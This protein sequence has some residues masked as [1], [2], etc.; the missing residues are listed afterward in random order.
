MPNCTL[1]VSPCTIETWLM[2]TPRR[3]AISWREGR[4]V[5]LAVAVRSRQ[6]L[7]GA[8]RIDADF[9]RLPQADAGAEAADRLRRRDAAGLDVAGDADAAQLAFRLRLGLAGGEAGIVDRLHRGVERGVKVAGVI[10]HDHR[11]LIREAGDEVLPA[12][13]GR[14]D[15]QLPRRGLHQPLEHEARLGPARAAIGVDRRGVG[16][17]ADH[18]GDR[19]SGCCTGPTAASRRDRSAPTTRTATCRRRNWRGS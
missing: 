3:S 11:R 17:D 13:F 18:L 8:D 19:C 15:L 14:I 2:G 9:R 16:V 5:A 1:S 10:G 4:L 12:Q 6:H 7:D